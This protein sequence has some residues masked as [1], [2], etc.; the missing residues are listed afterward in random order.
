MPYKIFAAGEEALASD[1]NSQLMSQTV[2]RFA[3]AAQRTSLLTA[4]VLNQLSILDTRPSAIQSWNGSAWVD[5]N[6]A[7][8]SLM[9][10]G[11]AGAVVTTNAA[12]QFT[13][14][15][16]AAFG[17]APAVTVCNGDPN[18]GQLLISV[19]AATVNTVGAPCVALVSNTAGPLANTAIRVAYIAVG[20]RP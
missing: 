18:Q 5:T 19:A 16:P 4:P 9:V 15:F 11:V 17:A 12:G 8:G 14:T 6:V 3:T 20:V 1:V 7:T 13:I 10:Q 2:A